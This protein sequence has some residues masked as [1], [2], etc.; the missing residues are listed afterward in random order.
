MQD[1]MFRVDCDIR[2]LL[3]ASE[4][5]NLSNNLIIFLNFLA[6]TINEALIFLTYVR[7][8]LLTCSLI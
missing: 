2:T 1:S 5:R 3:K 4:V 8:L 7:I 6:T